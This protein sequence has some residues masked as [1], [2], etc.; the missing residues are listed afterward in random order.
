MKLALSQIDKNTA[1][2]SYVF[3]NETDVSEL[4]EM[5]NDIR[6]ISPATVKAICTK[7]GDEIIF[8]LNIKGEAILPCARTLVD[9]TYPFDINADEVYTLS[10]Y[11]T[12]EDAENE[13]H[14]VKGEMLDLT[15]QIKENILLEI[16]F[17][18]FSDDSDAKK[19]VPTE[20]QGW[21]IVTEQT[22]DNSIDPRMKKLE[23]LLKDKKDK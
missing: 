8:S 6:K 1:R 21:E 19:N 5:N 15:P 12:E 4:V 2:G 14:E 10:P 20:G 3:E 17:R 9:V 13:I 18:V 23:E 7:Q 11:Y 22:E 16:P